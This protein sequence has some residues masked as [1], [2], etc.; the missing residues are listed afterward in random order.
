MPV[1]SFGENELFNQVSNPRGS[2][3]RAVQNRLM[4][5]FS[6]APALFFGRGIVPKIIGLMPHKRPVCTVGKNASLIEVDVYVDDIFITIMDRGV[7]EQG[8]AFVHIKVLQN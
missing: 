4:K 2:R 8:F 3:L 6:F 7:I 1:F 5:V